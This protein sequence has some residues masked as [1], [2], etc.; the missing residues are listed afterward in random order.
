M[1]KVKDLRRPKVAIVDNSIDPSIY[2]PVDHWS[3][4]LDAPWQAFVARHGEFPDPAGFSHII[5]TGSEASI[6]EREPWVEAEAAFVR[7][8]ATGGAAILGSCWGHQ[9]IAFAL[10]GESCVGRCVRP[11]I[12]WIPIRADRE[13]ELLGPAGTV[14]YAFSIHFDEVRDLPASFEVIA[15]TGTCP[16]H[17]FRA[18]D[19]PVWGLQSHPEMDIPT[20]LR[21]LRD[22]AARSSRGRDALLEA[23]AQTPRD[24]GIIHRVVRAFLAAPYRHGQ[25]A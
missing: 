12:G 17:A 14:Q 18:G 23:M 7:D 22:L 3:R 9:L 15:S 20:A 24:S 2:R 11:E 8:A 1:G 25:N 6:V 5:L 10:A 13:S 16:I 4:Y 19:K 21:T